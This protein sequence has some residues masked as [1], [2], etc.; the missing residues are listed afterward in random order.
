MACHVYN[1]R[2]RLS[3]YYKVMTIAVCDI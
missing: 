1:A 2:S 3:L